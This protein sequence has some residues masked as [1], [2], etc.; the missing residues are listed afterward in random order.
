[1]VFFYVIDAHDAL[2][3]NKPEPVRA[4]YWPRRRLSTWVE[5]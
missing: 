1:L 2:A 3:E 4:P 5:A